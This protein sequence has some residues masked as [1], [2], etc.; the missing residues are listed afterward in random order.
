MTLDEIRELIRLASETGVAELEVQRGDNRV[1]IRQSFGS[2][3]SVLLPSQL[4]T[5]QL[6]TY[7]RMVPALRLLDALRLPFGLSLWAVARR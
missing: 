2:D 5:G 7:D 4:S 3:T 1:R 6:R